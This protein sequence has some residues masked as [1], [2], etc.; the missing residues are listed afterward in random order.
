VTASPL[1]ARAVPAGVPSGRAP[2]LTLDQFLR[3]SDWVYRR[4]GIRFGSNKRYFVDK[5]ILAC[6]REHEGGFESWFRA[7]QNGSESPEAQQLINVLTVN[8]TYFL[9]EDYQFSIL[10]NGVLPKVL[11]AGRSRG[12]PD[13]V[14][15]LSLPCSTGEEPYSIA[16]HLIQSWP[17]LARVDVEIV[18][19][20]INTEVL[21]RARNGTYGSRSLQRVPAVTRR[22]WFDR[23]DGE[24]Y[25]VKAEIRDVIQF[26]VANLS[27]I[28]TM[29]ALRDFDVVFCR[30]LLIYFDELSIRRAAEALL[31]TLREGGYLFLGHSE[32]MNRI[33][34]IF[35]PVRFPEG[36]VYQ[37]PVPG[38]AS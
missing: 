26:T 15:I 37:R 17:D 30:N 16:L 28:V 6:A 14:R 32:S 24:H 12:D 21:E 1:R 5:R 33:A 9:R 18:A 27:D 7:V 19:A 23:V 13:H 31:G 4:T 36:I 10:V 29:R 3:V 25:Q 11:E 8:E 35:Q 20:D 34:P 22:L 38:A 2:V